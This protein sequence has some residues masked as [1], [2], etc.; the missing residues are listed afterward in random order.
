VAVACTV[1]GDTEEV[2]TIVVCVFDP[3]DRVVDAWMVLTI[4]GGVVTVTIVE[5]LG[6][7][8]VDVDDGVVV[9]VVDSQVEKI[10]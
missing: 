3:L 1:E 5:V 6:G 8:G 4:G 7:V 10:V 9:G 2:T